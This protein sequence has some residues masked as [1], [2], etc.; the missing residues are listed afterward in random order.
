MKIQRLLNEKKYEELI[1]MW[2]D[3]QYF[4][5]WRDARFTWEEKISLRE[6]LNFLAEQDLNRVGT[7]IN[8]YKPEELDPEDPVDAEVFV[9]WYE[10]CVDDN[11]RHLDIFNSW[12]RGNDIKHFLSLY[13]KCG[14]HW[15]SIKAGLRGI[16]DEN[17]IS[18]K[19]GFERKPTNW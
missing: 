11:I 18:G 2:I 19:V 13:K 9:I 3:P 7:Y 10:D 17:H 14:S 15:A 1:K 8:F 6:I 4:L 5:N 12:E 16:Y